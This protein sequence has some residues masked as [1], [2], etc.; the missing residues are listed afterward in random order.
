VAL[1]EIYGLD[2]VARALEDAFAFQ[3]FSCE[4]IANRLESR[5]WLRP[6]PPALHLTRRADLLELDL[7][8]PDLSVYTAGLPEAAAPPEADPKA[9]AEGV[10][11]TGTEGST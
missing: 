6:E 1:S 3:A 4:Y 7:P 2:P 8:P 10:G 5:A 11:D 9:D